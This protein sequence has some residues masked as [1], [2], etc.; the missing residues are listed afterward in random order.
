MKG[1][2]SFHASH[3][4]KCQGCGGRIARG[5]NVWAPGVKGQHYTGTS[6]GMFHVSC[7]PAVASRKASPLEIQLLK[8]AAQQRKLA[9]F[10]A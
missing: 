5:E 7:Q 8:E 3:A 2:L 10:D 6:Q 9:K 4:G 1:Q